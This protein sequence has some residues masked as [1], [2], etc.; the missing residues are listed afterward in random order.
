[1]SCNRE[2]INKSGGAR[3]GRLEKMSES[4]TLIESFDCWLAE[5]TNCN[6]TDKSLLA[7]LFRDRRIIIRQYN[8]QQ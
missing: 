1:M 5:F 6:P 2:S 7:M 4:V 8:R 3:K